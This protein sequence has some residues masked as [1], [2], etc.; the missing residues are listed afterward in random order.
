MKKSH[1]ATTAYEPIYPGVQNMFNSSNVIFLP[2]NPKKIE[3]AVF[4]R[5]LSFSKQI[6]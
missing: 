1:K 2:D 3:K 4:E 5:A 6:L